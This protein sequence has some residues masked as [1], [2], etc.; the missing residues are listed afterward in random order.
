MRSRARTAIA[1]A[2]TL[3][4]AVALV[5]HYRWLGPPYFEIPPTVQDHVWPAPFASRDVI[6]LAGRAAK[7]LPR[8]E[9]V[10]AIQPSN[11][12]NFDVTHFLTALGMMPKHRVIP[13]KLDT[14]PAELPRFV[15][16]VREEWTHPAYVHHSSYPEGHI[17]EV[18]R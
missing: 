12:P 13:P 11:A 8:G 10:T 14:S 16:S 4:M 5:R 6:L 2:A 3:V 18:Q 7:V 17:Y 15:L 1:I 9:T